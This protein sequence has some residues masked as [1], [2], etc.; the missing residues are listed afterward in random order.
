MNVTKITVN[1]IIPD[2]NQPRKYF[3]A[4]KLGMLKNSIK[5]HG[6]KEPLTL[7]LQKDGTYLIQNGERRFRAAKELGMKDVPAII[8]PATNAAQ[9]LIEQFHI[10][11]LHEGWSTVEKAVATLNLSELLKTSLEETAK[12]LA[13]PES[14]LRTLA[15][16]AKIIDKKSFERSNMPIRHASALN[17]TISVV[18][19]IAQDADIEFDRTTAKAFENAVYIR[20]KNGEEINTN[21]FSKIKDSFKQN[22]KLITEFIEDD[23]LTVDKL[24]TKSKARGSVYLRKMLSNAAWLASDI[25]SFFKDPSVKVN[26]ETFAQLKRA[27]EKIKE[28]LNKFE[29]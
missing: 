15:A 10:Q 22:P 17:G 29:E 6:I 4:A 14:A 13:M 23:S 8:V 1:K 18:R 3:D 25:D 2:E 11:E 26:K 12:I 7:E 21:F 24:F 9:R 28:F 16:F 5:T 27:Q 19:K 20:V